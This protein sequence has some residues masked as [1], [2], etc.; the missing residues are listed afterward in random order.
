MSKK[1]LT[2]PQIITKVSESVGINKKQ[3]KAAIE[4]LIE[5]A[6]KE[7]K[8]G[9]TIPGL[10]KFVVVNRKARWGRNPQTGEKIRIKAKKAL[11]FRIA[12]AAKDAV[13][14]KK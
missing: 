6:Y 2:K 11:K 12:K 8:T 4:A 13:T 1:A 14:G 5:M 9:F 10:G 7:A 3:A